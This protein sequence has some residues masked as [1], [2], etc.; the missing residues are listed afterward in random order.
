MA[1]SI[2]RSR[3]T[4]DTSSQPETTGTTSLADGSTPRASVVVAV[5]NSRP[6]LPA[7]LA[8]L[9]RQTLPAGEFEVLLCDDGSTDGSAAWLAE[10]LDPLK[11][12]EL[13]VL[14]A[15]HRGPAAARNLGARHARGE[16]IA[17]TDSDCAPDP[18]WLEKILAAFR[19][20]SSLVAVEGVT[21]SSP[22]AASP[23]DHFMDLPGGGSWAT[24]NV[25]YRRSAFERLGGFDER[26]PYGHE[27]TE[28]AIRARALGPMRFE[29]A[30][31][32]NHPPVRRSFRRVVATYRHWRDDLVL[33]ECQPQAYRNG[34]G[35]RGPLHGILVARGIR[36]ALSDLAAKRRFLAARPLAF[37]AY[38]LAV[39]AS[40]LA[41]LADLPRIGSWYARARR[42]L[43]RSRV[44]PPPT[45]RSSRT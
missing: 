27:D 23:F 34:L 14:V 2:S 38:A 33:Y 29:P 18:D 5:Y 36:G 43:A 42:R 10:L 13:R 20:D 25:A 6:T 35:G 9:E 16:V 19:G 1:L 41:L 26:F 28:L 32:V 4:R 11:R 37:I 12:P 3:E 39:A 24:C 8:A 17:F 31:R 45:E 15:A 7:L 44:T 30:V 40:R 22:P 21:Y